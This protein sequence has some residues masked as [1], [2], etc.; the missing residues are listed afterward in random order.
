M[1]SQEGQE[2]ASIE[3]PSLV[4]EEEMVPHAASKERFVCLTACAASDH[5]GDKNEEADDNRIADDKSSRDDDEDG[6][7]PW[8]VLGLVHPLFADRLHPGPQPR[9]LKKK[10][11][12]IITSANAHGTQDGSNDHSA[13]PANEN[14]DIVV[15]SSSQ[16]VEREKRKRDSVRSRSGRES[17]LP[18]RFEFAADEENAANN[19]AEDT[20]DDDDDGTLFQ[21]LAKRLRAANAAAIRGSRGGSGQQQCR[22]KATG[23]GLIDTWEQRFS[24]LKEY[25]QLNG[26]C[27]VPRRYEANLPLAYWVGK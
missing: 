13:P 12:K 11:N 26:D 8:A 24:E 15:A 19:G 10:T 18:S 7:S 25:C 2:T 16:A 20:D 17:K 3:Q 1:D 14:N 5:G 21:G 27:L 23:R 4:D 9:R 6:D 22:P